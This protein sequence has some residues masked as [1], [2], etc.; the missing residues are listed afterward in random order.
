MP[1]LRSIKCYHSVYMLQLI[2]SRI[3]KYFRPAARQGLAEV[4]VSFGHPPPAPTAQ[5]ADTALMTRLLN[6]AT[7]DPT[8]ELTAARVVEQFGSF[9]RILST[10]ERELLAVR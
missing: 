6:L 10:T 7:W 8:P 2:Q 1:R 9:A 3:A 5:H 4:P